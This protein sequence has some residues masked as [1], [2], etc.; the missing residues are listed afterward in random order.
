[1]RIWNRTRVSRRG[2]TEDE[3]DVR[4]TR[5]HGRRRGHDGLCG[6]GARAA[7]GKGRG[8]ARRRWR[9]SEEEEVVA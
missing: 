5:P 3:E 8:M 4:R 1:M 6:G 9:R 7:V 2:G